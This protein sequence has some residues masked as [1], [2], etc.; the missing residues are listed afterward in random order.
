MPPPRTIFFGI[1]IYAGKERAFEQSMKSLEDNLR[2]CGIR[3]VIQEMWGES[4]ITRARNRLV[5][6]FLQS[7]ATDFMFI[8]AD[9]EF[10]ASD[11]LR[12]LHSGHDFCGAPY[13]AKDFTR[14]WL[15]GNPRLGLVEGDQ[16]QVRVVDGWVEAQDIPTGFMFVNRSVFERLSDHVVEVIDDMPGQAN[17]GRYKIF[18]DTGASQEK[19]GQYLSEDWYFSRLCLQHGIQGWL[20]CRSHLRHWGKYPYSAPSLEEAWAEKIVEATE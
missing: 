16:A 11:V 1:P 8:D 20:D 3:Y 7:P 19:D 12:L 2:K 9:I 13:P 10:K 14:Q 15:V 17:Q 18:F 4:L 6:L 5:D